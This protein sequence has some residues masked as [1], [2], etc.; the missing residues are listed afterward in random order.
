MRNIVLIFAGVAFLLWLSNFDNNAITENLQVYSTGLGKAVTLLVSLFI[1]LSFYNSLCKYHGAKSTEE[2]PQNLLHNPVLRIT[3]IH[4]ALY[5]ALMSF[6]PTFTGW[7]SESGNNV[8]NF[9]IKA[10]T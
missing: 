3:L 2:K 4:I 1:S 10:K 8:A 6:A 5:V 9:I 7:I